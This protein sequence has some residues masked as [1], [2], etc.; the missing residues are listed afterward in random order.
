MVLY[1]NYGHVSQDRSVRPFSFWL[2]P[3]LPSRLE[4]LRAATLVRLPGT[5]AARG[6]TGGWSM[7]G[8]RVSGDAQG[9][10]AA[11]YVARDGRLAERRYAVL[12]VR[13]C[14]R[15]V[16]CQIKRVSKAQT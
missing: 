14:K 10:W 13:A 6:L 4:R 15:H 1:S 12:P 3:F 8:F 11:R 7:A 2:S 9:G 5:A 16:Q